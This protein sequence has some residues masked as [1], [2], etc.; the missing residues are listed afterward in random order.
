MVATDTQYQAPSYINLLLALVKVQQ[1]ERLENQP[2][3]YIL[4]AELVAEEKTIIT[5]HT[6]TLTVEPVE[7]VE[8]VEVEEVGEELV[9]EQ[10]IIM[11][12]K[13]ALAV[14]EEDLAAQMHM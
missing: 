9:A 10:V 6:D 5:F 7:L 4:L 3:N 2:E 13:A 11:L 8:T 12:E 1:L 14:Q